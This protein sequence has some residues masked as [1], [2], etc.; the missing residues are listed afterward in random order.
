MQAIH[1]YRELFGEV[2]FPVGTVPREWLERHALAA[3]RIALHGGELVNVD[4][5]AL[6]HDFE[7]R[8]A[9]L[10]RKH[11]MRHLDI[12]ELRSRYR[13]V[14][15]ALS[16]WLFDQGAA[17]ILYRSNLDNLPCVALFEGRATVAASDAGEADPPDQILLVPVPPL[18]LLERDPELLPRTPPELLQVCS[19]FG[20]TLPQ[21]R[22]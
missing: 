14:T 12:S 19:E 11:G 7:R 18:S 21:N 13:Q 5:P 9:D 4:D 16:R 8:H 15:Q 2:P 1:E 22:R 6:R 10:L 3:G 20:L 17:G